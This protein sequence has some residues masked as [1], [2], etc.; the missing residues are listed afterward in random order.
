MPSFQKS[1]FGKPRS[2]GRAAGAGLSRDEAEAIG[3]AAFVF[4]AEDEARLTR[5]LEATGMVAGDLRAA[6]G[7][8]ETLSAVLDHVLSDESL[9]LVFAAGAGIEPAAIAPAHAALVEASAT[10]GAKR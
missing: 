1:S 3:I 7:S 8:P 6:A 5:F 9:L 2:S 10:G 4:L